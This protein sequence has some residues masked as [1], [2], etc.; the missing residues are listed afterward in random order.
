M[1][2]FCI[3]TRLQCKVCIGC[4]VIVFEQPQRNLSFLGK[5]K[6]P[7]LFFF[8]NVLPRC[9]ICY[10]LLRSH[11]RVTTNRT[12]SLPQSLPPNACCLMLSTKFVSLLWSPLT[13]WMYQHLLQPLNIGRCNMP[14]FFAFLYKNS[15]I[16]NNKG[17]LNS[18]AFH[19]LFPFQRSLPCSLSLL[20]CSLPRRVASL[21]TQIF[22]AQ[23]S[24]LLSP[25]PLPR[26]S[27]TLPVSATPMPDP[28]SINHPLFSKSA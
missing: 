9:C 17:T 10:N 8:T 23:L 6:E 19:S 16:A 13:R 18:P 15:S 4:V 27:G 25:L 22:D 11:Y 24:C 14:L 12:V 28:N 21:L 2:N 5:P 26:L 7:L 3:N 1:Y 20:S